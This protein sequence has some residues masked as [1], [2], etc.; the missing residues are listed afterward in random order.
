MLRLWCWGCHRLGPRKTSWHGKSAFRGLFKWMMNR[1]RNQ[2][3]KHLVQVRAVDQTAYPLQTSVALLATDWWMEPWLPACFRFETKLNQSKDFSPRMKTSCFHTHTHMIIPNNV[4]ICIYIY[5]HYIY[6]HVCVYIHN[7][8]IH[9]IWY[10]YI[11]TYLY[12]YNL[13]FIHI[14]YI[15]ISITCVFPRI[16]TL[17]HVHWIHMLYLTLHILSPKHLASLHRPLK[18]NSH[19]YQRTWFIQQWTT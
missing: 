8:Y 13:Y 14:T 11:I 9:I 6:T 5:T 2:Q 10:I 15:Y 16:C 18:Q 12:V 4:Y 19:S 17:L 7:I 1:N 3:Y